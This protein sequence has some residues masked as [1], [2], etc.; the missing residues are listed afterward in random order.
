MSTNL[1]LHVPLVKLWDHSRQLYPEVLSAE[2]WLHLMNCEHCVDVL[3]CCY[4][5]DSIDQVKERI[6]LVS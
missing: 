3:R 6:S 4:K 5:A 1:G 2:D